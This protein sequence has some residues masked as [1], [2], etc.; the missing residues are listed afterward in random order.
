MP[1]GLRPELIPAAQY[2]RMSKDHQ[3]Y[4]IR[5]QARA[6]AAYASQHGY[7]IVRTYTDPGESGLTLRERP[8]L[9]ALLADVIKPMR[10]FER[11]MVLDVSRWGRFQNLDESGH[12]EFICYEAGVPVIYCAEMFE[13]DGSPVMALLKQFKRLQ[14]A[15]FSRELSQKVLYAQLLQARI[16]HKLGGPRR[17]GFERI[18]VDEYDRPIQKLET[19]QTKALNNQ[20]VVYAIGPDDEVKV[21]RDIFTWYTRDRMSIREI[22]KRLNE[23]RISAVD[24]VPWKEG[25]VRRMLADELVIGIYAFNRTTQKLKTKRRKNPPEALI[26]T[27]VLEPIISRTLFESAARRLRIRRHHVPPEENLAAVARLYRAKGYL[28]VKLIDQCLYAPSQHV[29][30]EQFGSIQRVYELV[31]FKPAGWWRPPGQERPA[32]EEEMLALLRRLFERDGY[33]SEKTLN[34]DSSVP[35]ASIYQYHFGTLTTAYR[36]AGLPHRQIELQRLGLERLKAK[37]AGEPPRKYTMPRWTELK[38]KYTDEDLFDCLR[39][40]HRLYGYVTANII[41]RDEASPPPLF[42]IRRF[43]TLLNA[44]GLAG[45]ENRRFN[46]W[47][48]AARARQATIAEKKAPLG[49][50]IVGAPSTRFRV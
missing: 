40:L 36:L 44:Y 26:K 8:G 12:Y 32:T 37:R 3:R 31:G 21:I 19:G 4:S 25:R 33:V 27:K 13:N 48:R 22:A 23:L 16:G 29:L 28:T 2:L 11:L 45:L 9:Q 42:F 35:S 46:I 34:S 41:R 38:D 17:F 14:A 43:G 1:N 47:S 30:L 7:N 20:R 6:I 24:G 18:L 10:P 15:E 49:A 39:R 5:N 50:H